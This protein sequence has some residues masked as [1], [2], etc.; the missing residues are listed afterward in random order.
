MSADLIWCAVW[1]VVVVLCVA[2]L[3][4]M[5]SRRRTPKPELPPEPHPFN[6]EEYI[7]TLSAKA[8]ALADEL[9]TLPALQSAATAK[10]VSDAIA[11]EAAS[12]DADLDGLKAV[13]D[14]IVAGVT[15][16]APVV[17]DPPVVAPS[18]GDPEVIVPEVAS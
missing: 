14:P 12:H 15:P 5:A 13:V 16:D 3:C 8:Q 2:R 17:T 18:D 11:A 4:V 1:T 9:A 6:L 7:M 10:A